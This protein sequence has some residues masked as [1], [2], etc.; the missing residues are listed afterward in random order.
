MMW[1]EHC[2]EIIEWRKSHN[3][4]GKVKINHQGNSKNNSKTD[5]K[6]MKKMI[7][8]AVA[9]YLSQLAGS[10]NLYDREEK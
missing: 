3:N 10:D 9:S 2:D 7:C 1:K 5:N 4:G 6:S 8:V